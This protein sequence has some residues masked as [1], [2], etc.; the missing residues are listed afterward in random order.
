MFSVNVEE[1]DDAD[2]DGERSRVTNDVKALDR[3]GPWVNRRM[4]DSRSR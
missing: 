2:D 3:E 1:E 4:E